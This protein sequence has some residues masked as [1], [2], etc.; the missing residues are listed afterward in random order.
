MTALETLQHYRWKME[1]KK[2][3]QKLKHKQNEMTL[4]NLLNSTMFE[5]KIV[6]FSE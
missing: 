3:K 5:V 2:Q 6:R 4:R 1:R